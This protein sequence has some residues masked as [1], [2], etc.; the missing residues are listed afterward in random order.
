M[1]RFLILGLFALLIVIISLVRLLAEREFFRLTTM[2]KI[3]GRKPGLAMHFLASV[4]LP[5]VLGIIFLTQGVNGFTPR[6][7]Q[8]SYLHG[9]SLDLQAISEDYAQQ[10]RVLLQ[11]QLHAADP[12]LC[13]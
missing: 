10:R 9:R 6:G 8:E 3:W 5:L 4:G 11:K 13:P 12:V 1:N 7:T 2:K